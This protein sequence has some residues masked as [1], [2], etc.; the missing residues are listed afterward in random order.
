MGIS[1]RFY[2][3]SAAT[4]TVTALM[5]GL[6]VPAAAAE[7][8]LQGVAGSVEWNF[9]DSFMSYVT[10]SFADGTVTATEGASWASGQPFTFPI[11]QDSSEVIDQ[12]TANL[13]LDGVVNF[14]A[15]GGV[16]DITVSDLELRIDGDTAE[17]YGDYLSRPFSMGDAQEPVQGDDQLIV[18]IEF[19]GPVD[20]RTPLDLTGATTLAESGVPVLSNYKAGDVFSDLQ[21]NTEPVLGEVAPEEP[22]DP[23]APAE[24]KDETG[25]S[26]TGSADNGSSDGEG[27]FD[28]LVDLLS[29]VLGLGSIGAAIATIVKHFSNLR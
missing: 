21:L 10:G 9:K 13:D 27:L 17:L 22:G 12:D 28:G 2:A 3:T 18:T 4:L 6:T 8:E 7:T 15:H 11:N 19:V 1:R 29:A 14:N 20:L 23:V 24:P 26:E 5:T 25:D 16:L